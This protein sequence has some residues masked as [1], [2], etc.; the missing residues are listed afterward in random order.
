MQMEEPWSLDKESLQALRYRTQFMIIVLQSLG[1]TSYLEGCFRKCSG[2]HVLAL[3]QLH[4]DTIQY[5]LLMF[6][7]ALKGL[8]CMAVDVYGLLHF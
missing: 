2:T 8:I 1:A 5:R 7:I 3:Q 4:S 6:Y